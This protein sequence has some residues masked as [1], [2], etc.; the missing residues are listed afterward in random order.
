M[1]D[2][3]IWIFLGFLALLEILAVPVL[4]VV[5]LIL[6]FVALKYL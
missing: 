6:G 4:F 3:A 5:V 2:A 1:D